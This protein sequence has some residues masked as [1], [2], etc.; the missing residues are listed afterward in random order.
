[1]P[2]TDACA[3]SSTRTSCHLTVVG[4]GGAKELKGE[5]GVLDEDMVDVVEERRLEV[6]KLSASFFTSTTVPPIR[7]SSTVDAARASRCKIKATAGKKATTDKKHVAEV[8]YKELLNPSNVGVADGIVTNVLLVE[9]ASSRNDTKL[10]IPTTP[11][12]TPAKQG[13]P[14]AT[15]QRKAAA[16]S[17]AAAAATMTGS[18]K[19]VCVTGASGY[20]ASWVVR[21]LLDRGYT[22]RATVRDTADPKK[23]LHLTALDGAKDR[24]HL[25]KASLLEEGSFEP[26]CPTQSCPYYQQQLIV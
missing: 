18:G 22:V 11:V 19:V 13:G 26:D 8:P 5:P 1:M 17:S 7:P 21:L 16:M 12:T 9:T 24:L 23:T 14:G 20:I 6:A 4:F 2:R 3:A 15:Q 10:I 25:F